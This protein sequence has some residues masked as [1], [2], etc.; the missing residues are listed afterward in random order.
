VRYRPDI[1]ARGAGIDAERADDRGDG[2]RNLV[3]VDID[4]TCGQRTPSDLGWLKKTKS[5]SLVT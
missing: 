1:E 2:G 3:E 4:S 5:V